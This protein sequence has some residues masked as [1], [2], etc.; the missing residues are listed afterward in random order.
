MIRKPQK[1]LDIATAF[2]WVETPTGFIRAPLTIT[3]IP[4]PVATTT[5]PDS[6]FSVVIRTTP[7]PTPPP[8]L[9]G[10]LVEVTRPTRS[11]IR[12]NQLFTRMMAARAERGDVPDPNE[13]LY[14][15]KCRTQ[16]N[17]ALAKQEIIHEPP[18][19]CLVTYRTYAELE[20]G[21]DFVTPPDV[22]GPSFGE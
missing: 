7:T 18:V 19:Y 3:V 15:C 10:W 9:E 4:P 12:V 17:T 1:F 8:E 11:R 21:R 22:T 14:T 6:W 2:D 13:L 16:L 20:G 5:P